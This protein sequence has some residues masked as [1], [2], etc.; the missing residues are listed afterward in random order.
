MVSAHKSI[1][2]EFSIFDGRSGF[3][4]F[5]DLLEL[6]KAGDFN[7]TK[8]EI[9]E[10]NNINASNFNIEFYRD[11]FGLFVSKYLANGLQLVKIS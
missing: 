2:N 9:G 4:C 8:L 7:Q 11:E 6:I 10:D 3:K 5:S 1:Y